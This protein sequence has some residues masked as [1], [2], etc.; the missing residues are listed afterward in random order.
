M[1]GKLPPGVM[2][3][4][5]YSR[6]GRRDPS[7][8]VGPAVGEDAA[9]IDLGDGRVLVVHNDA[10]TGAVEFL[11]WL[12]VHI[13][14]NDV[15]VRGARPRWFLMSLFLPERGAEALLERVMA[16]VDRAAR[17][18]GMM[19]V[20]GHTETTPG[21]DRPIVGTT[22]IGLASRDAYVTTSGA[23]S[24][25]Y[26][27]VTKGVG[28]EGTAIMCTDF[29]EALRS[30]GV[31]EEVIRRGA[32]FLEMVSVAREALLLA[33]HGLVT[34]MHDPTEGGLLGGL[35]ELAYASG[36]T[37]VVREADVPLAEETRVVTQ[38]L[39]VDPLRLISSGTLVATVPPPRVEEAVR[40]LRDNGIQA[41]VIGRVVDFNGNLVEVERRDGSRE[42]LREVY[43]ADELFRLW[44]A[45]GAGG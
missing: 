22:A 34:A 24:G 41:R 13:V 37:I 33:E 14:A 23:R 4:L 29:A 42:V 38:A 36:K 28:I 27:I 3:K 8:L 10:I 2:E 5:V 9:I 32:R 12:A 11:G 39:G 15:A 20:G 31:S 26:V 18:L 17:E 35:A 25:D 43:V 40:L 19:V 7:V 21:L 1:V 45:Y 6:L 30:R 16:Q 44:K